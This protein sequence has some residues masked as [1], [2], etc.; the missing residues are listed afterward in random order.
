MINNQSSLEALSSDGDGDGILTPLQAELT[1]HLVRYAVQRALW[2]P[3]CDGVLDTASSALVTVKDT[4]AVCWCERCLKAMLT[5][6]AKRNKRTIA[7]VLEQF[8]RPDGLDLDFGSAALQARITAWAKWP[9]G[10][11]RE[12]CQTLSPDSV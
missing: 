8:A 2:C 12:K 11:T 10:V 3:E 6:I 5:A 4:G 7:D 9:T 1:R